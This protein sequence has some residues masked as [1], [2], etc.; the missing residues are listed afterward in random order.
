M[1]SVSDS[2]RQL[3]PLSALYT[4]FLPDRAIISSRH[5]LS[6]RAGLS[7]PTRGRVHVAESLA[8]LSSADYYIPEL[9]GAPKGT[10]E[11]LYG[12]HIE[13]SN[14]AIKASSDAY[15][16]FLLATNRHIADKPRLVIWLNGMS[17]LSCNGSSTQADLV[18][19]P[20]TA[21]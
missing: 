11:K 19:R 12:G 17:P 21:R 9:P 20:L 8:E 15:L 13:A 2:S 10:R 1:D 14:A 6:K 4:R 16:F 18:A 7:A 3:Q 5:A